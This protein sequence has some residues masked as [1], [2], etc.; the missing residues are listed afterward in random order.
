MTL[1][2]NNSKKRKYNYPYRPFFWSLHMKATDT[3]IGDGSAGK[4]KSPGEDG[5]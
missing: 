1:Y 5:S 3:T 2:K 4:N